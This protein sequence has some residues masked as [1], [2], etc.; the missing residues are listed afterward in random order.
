[1]ASPSVDLTPVDKQSVSF[2][3]CCGEPELESLAN[4]DYLCAKCKVQ[5]RIIASEQIISVQGLEV[6]R[7]ARKVRRLDQNVP[8]T[9]LEFKVLEFLILHKGIVYYRES[10]IK[11]VWTNNTNIDR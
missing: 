6:H 8:I 5:F 10:I 11:A 9:P 7:E 2:C 4:C 1:M 3:P